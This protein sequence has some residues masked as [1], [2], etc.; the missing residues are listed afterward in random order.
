MTNGLFIKKII[1]KHWLGGIW[2]LNPAFTQKNY[3]L[4]FPYIITPDFKPLRFLRNY[5]Y[6]LF[7]LLPVNDIANK[8]EKQCS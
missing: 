5:Y 2:R 7:D 8:L 1:T 3:G 4:G 6:P